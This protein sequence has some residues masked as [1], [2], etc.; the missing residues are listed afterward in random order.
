M[1][2]QDEYHFDDDYYKVDM[3]IEKPIKKRKPKKRDPTDIVK[4]DAKA[5]ARVKKLN[6]MINKHEAKI[7]KEEIIIQ[8]LQK[9]MIALKKKFGI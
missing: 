7:K 3:P 4:T 8:T 1:K 2:Q 6:D 9:E 5:S